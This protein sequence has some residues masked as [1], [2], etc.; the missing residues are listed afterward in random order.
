MCKLYPKKTFKL[1]LMIFDLDTMF[2][3]TCDKR[4][5]PCVEAG[6]VLLSLA[7]VLGLELS[8]RTH[9][10]LGLGLEG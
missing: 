10:V 2:T 9:L 4:A 7:L 5:K 1:K 3:Q 6:P 8:L